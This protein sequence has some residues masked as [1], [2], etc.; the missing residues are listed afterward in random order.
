MTITTHDPEFVVRGYLASFADRDP[1]AIAAFVAPDFVNEHSAGLGSGCR[2]R[3]VYRE[4]LKGF[5]Q[6]MQGLTYSIE[7][8]VHDAT[9]SEVAAFYTMSARWQGTA[10][11]SIHGAQRL[12]VTD[13][14]ITHRNDYWDSALFLAQVDADARSTL[15][16]FGISV[17]SE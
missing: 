12:V 2:G 11:F 8:L 7:H 15:S 9:R 16:G 13:G 17:S 5:L 10:P 6:D 1:D 14:L 4:R 3:D